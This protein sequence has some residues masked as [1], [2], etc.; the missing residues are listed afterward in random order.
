MPTFRA[1]TVSNG[2]CFTTVAG[3]PSH[4][5]RFVGLHFKK[6]SDAAYLGRLVQI[7]SEDALQNGIEK[8][9]HHFI[10]ERCWWDAGSTSS[11][12]KDGIRLCADYSS[13][14]DSYMAEFKVDATHA[15]STA[16]S[17]INC[18][19]PLSFMNNYLGTVFGDCQQS[20]GNKLHSLEHHWIS[21]RSEYCVAD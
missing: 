11:Q 6:D 10:F 18:Q 7:G 19:G 1:S 15:D 3:I 5:Y 14:V 17:V 2:T 9:P 16:I 21:S 20:N 12:V 13:I 4:H 8:I